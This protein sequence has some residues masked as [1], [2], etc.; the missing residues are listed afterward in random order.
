M[1][2]YQSKNLLFDMIILTFIVIASWAITIY[3]LAKITVL[4][5]G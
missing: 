2:N 1:K 4:P 3:I 5:P